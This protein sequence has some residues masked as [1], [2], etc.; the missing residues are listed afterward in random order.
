[1]TELVSYQVAIST[2]IRLIP[3][4]ELF[5]LYHDVY[6]QEMKES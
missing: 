3:T 2:Q 1:M 5:P 4:R 6:H